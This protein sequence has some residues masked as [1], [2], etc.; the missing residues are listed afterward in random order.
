MNQLALA[1]LGRNAPNA[2]TTQGDVANCANGNWHWQQQVTPVDAIP[3]LLSITVSVQRTGDASPN[4][5]P[6]DTQGSASSGSSG[7]TFGDRYQLRTEC[8]PASN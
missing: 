1:R 8:T 2:G 6:P 3:G 7:H 5:R 4:S